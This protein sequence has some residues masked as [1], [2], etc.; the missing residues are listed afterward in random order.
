MAR[1]RKAPAFLVEATVR[2]NQKLIDLGNDEARLGFFYVVLGEAKLLDP[3]GQFGS[4][5]HFRELAGRFAPYTEDYIRVGILESGAKLCRR[6]ADK[7]AAMPPKR[8][9][10]V[11]HDWHEHQYDPRKVERQREYEERQREAAE[12]EAAG[13]SDGVSDAISDGVSDAKPGEFPTGFPTPI[14]HAPVTPASRDRV[15]PDASN[16]EHRTTNGISHEEIRRP[17]EREDIAA[18]LERPGWTKVT[19]AQR[20]V[21]N[22]IAGRHDVTGYAFAAEAIRRARPDEDPLQAAMTADR[23]W[24]EARRH[25]ADVDEAA[26][27]REKADERRD[28][29]RLGTDEPESIDWMAEP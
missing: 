3:P 19:R 7:W 28:A 25:K 21:L 20:K 13:V 24:Q 4:R 5:D 15:G 23:L 8:Q 27:Q 6:C 2:R 9:A 14:S 22:E 10:L 12:A 17:G 29:T 26:W 11:V 1:P 18:L 16:V